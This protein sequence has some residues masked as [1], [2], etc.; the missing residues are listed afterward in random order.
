MKKRIAIFGGGPAAL[1]F[2]SFIDPKKYIVTI[3]EQNK[4]CGRKFLVAGKGGFNL[5][6]GEALKTL[7]E[8]YLPSSFLSKSLDTFTNQDFR[9]WLGSIGIETFVGSSNRVFPIKGIKPVE[10]LNCILEH[11]VKRGIGIE[12]QKK[13]NGWNEGGIP[14]LADD[15]IIEAD[16]YIFAFG[17][18]S[19][20]VTGS[21]GIWKAVFESIG[22]K[23]NDFRP[24]N[25]AFKVVWPIQVIQEL[26]GKPLKN[27]SIA[28]GEKT[29]KGEVVITKFGLEGNAIYGLSAPIRNQLTEKGEAQIYLDLK[30]MLSKEKLVERY[31]RSSAKNTSSFL[32][33]D[34]KL[35][36]VQSKFLKGMTTREVFVDRKKMIELTNRLPLTVVDM[37]PIDEAISTIGGIPFDELN[38]YFE[39]NKVKKSFCIGEMVDWDAPTGGYLLQACFSMGVYLAQFLNNIEGK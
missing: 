9:K 2:A 13:W 15:T 31:D 4:T 38:E 12:Y 1:A 7:K 10:V 33:S 27:I 19:W 21:S 11:I 26:E 25:C 16:Y 32:K 17:G 24:S 28:C 14:K 18:A 20:K 30:P 8:R 22:I 3:Y 29:Q 6:H 5:T 34:V 23:V 39:L 37:A 36:K 35:S